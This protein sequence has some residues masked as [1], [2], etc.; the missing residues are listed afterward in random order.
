MDFDIVKSP[1][2]CWKLKKRQITKQIELPIP[3]SIRTLGQKES[4]NY[5]KM[6]EADTIKERDM[7]EKVGK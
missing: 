6:L 3:E 5:L 1:S 2:W 7:K 4:Y